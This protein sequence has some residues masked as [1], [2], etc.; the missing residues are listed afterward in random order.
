[1]GRAGI[2]ALLWIAFGLAA[3]LANLW[4]VPLLAFGA[5]LLL[6]WAT[7]RGRRPVAVVAALAAVR[8]GLL[9]AAALVYPACAVPARLRLPPTCRRN[10]VP[11]RD[12]K[13]LK[14][15]ETN[16]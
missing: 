5:G 2:A 10:V 7:S 8:T 16:L 6:L 14:N 3:A 1:M 12:P 15:L 4:N 11:T 13:C 9:L